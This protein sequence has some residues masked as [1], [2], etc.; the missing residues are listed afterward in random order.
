M[1][2]LSGI[3][4]APLLC[5]AYCLAWAQLTDA[6]YSTSVNGPSQVFISANV[7]AAGTLTLLIKMPAT[8][9]FYRGHR[10]TLCCLPGIVSLIIM[11]I[12][13]IFTQLLLCRRTRLTRAAAR[14]ELRT[15]GTQ[16][17]SRSTAHGAQVV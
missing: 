5:V 17:A 7:G 12:G 2:S 13:M 9:T 4:S 8:V 1:S 10:R 11:C 3:Y 6:C 15:S 14:I 16:R